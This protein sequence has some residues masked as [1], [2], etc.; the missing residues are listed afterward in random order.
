MNDNDERIDGTDVRSVK[1]RV[2]INVNASVLY[3]PVGHSVERDQLWEFMRKFG[4]SARIG[5][6]LVERN[7]LTFTEGDCVEIIDDDCDGGGE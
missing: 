4:P 6:Q 5:G 1:R 3:Q 2:R 7:S